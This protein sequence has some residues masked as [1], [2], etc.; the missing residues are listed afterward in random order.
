MVIPGSLTHLSSQGVGFAVPLFLHSPTE[1]AHFGRARL[2]QGPFWVWSRLLINREE[3]PDASGNFPGM[4]GYNCE[5]ELGAR[6]R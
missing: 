6:V 4:T 3:A 5:R 2:K 1:M